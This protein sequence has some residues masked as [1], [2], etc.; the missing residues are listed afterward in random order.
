M[1][2]QDQIRRSGSRSTPA[3][4]QNMITQ[5]MLA[6]YVELQ[7]KKKRCEELRQIILRLFDAHAEVELGKFTVDL[8]SS[9]QIRL[10][11][12]NLAKIVD[13]DDLAWLKE[14]VEPTVTRRLVVGAVNKEHYPSRGI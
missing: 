1:A 5:R 10:T 14:H 9:T 12:A 8:Q 7:E 3:D 13:A 6:E 11:A 2:F 4:D